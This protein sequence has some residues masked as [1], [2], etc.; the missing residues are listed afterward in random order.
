M[1]GSMTAGGGFFVEGGLERMENDKPS[2]IRAH[3]ISE[4]L[5]AIGYDIISITG[6]VRPMFDEK[7]QTTTKRGIMRLEILPRVREGE[8]PE[9]DQG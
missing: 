7:T 9:E 4:T 5:D 2:K 1:A 3:I 6:M 8:F